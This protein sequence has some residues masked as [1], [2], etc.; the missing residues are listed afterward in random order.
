MTRI[1]GISLNQAINMMQ[2][3]NVKIIDVKSRE[4]YLRF[5]LNNSI[6]IPIDL[7]YK[8]VTKVLKN[9]KENIIV[10]CSSGYRS[11]AACEMLVDLGYKNIFNIYT[12]VSML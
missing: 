5:H 8:N 11:R 7:F 10:Y 12:G 1:K 9:K 4:E 6:N 3:E 2:N